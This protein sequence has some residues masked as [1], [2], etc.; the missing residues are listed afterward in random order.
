M[1]NSKRAYEK[2]NSKSEVVAIILPITKFAISQ[3]Y[4]KNSL[5]KIFQQFLQIWN[6]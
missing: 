2:Q 4:L 1:F 3:S 6:T 5:T